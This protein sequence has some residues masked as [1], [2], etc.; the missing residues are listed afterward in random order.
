MSKTATK[1]SA[2]LEARLQ[3][4]E[5]VAEEA[6]AAASWTA[7]V[8]ALTKAK[9]IESEMVRATVAR[10][11][12]ETPDVL[13]RL[14][15]AAELALTD[16]SYGAAAAFME[17]AEDVRAKRAAEEAARREREAAGADPVK[18]KARLVTALRNLPTVLRDEVV[19]EAQA[20]EVH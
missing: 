20:A 16:G 7:V 12:R 17:Q 13:V 19:E 6:R 15:R 14:E 2:R 4:F 10:E 9:E 3:K 1:Q 8:S 11:L 18:L 5:Q